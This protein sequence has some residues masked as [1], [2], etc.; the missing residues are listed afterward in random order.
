[1]A[2]MNSPG[3]ILPTLALTCEQAFI[4]QGDPSK[5]SLPGGQADGKVVA[6]KLPAVTNPSY[7]GLNFFEDI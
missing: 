6:V 3:F 5:K 1:M 2:A 7:F 4:H